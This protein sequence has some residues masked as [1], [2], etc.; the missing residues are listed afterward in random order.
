MAVTFPA[1]GSKDDGTRI[2]APLLAGRC[3]ECSSGTA[4]EKPGR[5]C[6]FFRRGNFNSSEESRTILLICF[7]IIKIL[8]VVLHPSLQTGSDM[9]QVVEQ[10]HLCKLCRTTAGLNV[11]LQ[12]TGKQFVATMLLNLQIFCVLIWKLSSWWIHQAIATVC[13]KSI[14]AGKT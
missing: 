1:V 4:A 13:V 8:L 12:L 5:Y 6:S 14:T 2:Q 7:R 9:V 11:C 10:G 3:T